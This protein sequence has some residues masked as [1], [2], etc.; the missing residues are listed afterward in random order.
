MTQSTGSW[1]LDPLVAR[2]KRQVHLDWIRAALS[3]NPAVAVKTDLFEEA[4]NEDRIL[5]DLFPQ[6]RLVLGFDLNERTVRLAA[7]RRENFQSKVGDV[8]RLA[9]RDASVDV[10][11]STSTLDHFP[12]RREIAASLD[13]LHRVL[14][15]GGLLFIT[16]DN[17]RNPLYP[18]LRWAARRGWLPF[19]LGETL[20]LP[21]FEAMLVQ[22]GFAI[23]SSRYLIHNPR[24]ISTLLFL[25]LR[26][27]LGRFADT[28]I[29]ILLSTFA[30]AS[31]LPS[32]S[33][34]ACFSAVIAVKAN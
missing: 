32:R 8:R 20:P 10:A 13:E 3:L 30:L 23:Q 2:Q 17:P 21:Q 12:S 28:P 29:R 25:T 1:Y 15:P 4:H 31:R 24:G 7:A 27:L 18:P 26:K 34:T 33:L 22:R 9:L 6:C 19:A 16:L 5:G 11:V 14:R